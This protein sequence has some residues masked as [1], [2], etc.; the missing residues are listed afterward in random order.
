MLYSVALLARYG[1]SALSAVWDSGSISDGPQ[2]FKLRMQS[3]SPVCAFLVHLLGPWCICLQ[4][5]QHL[6]TVQCSF[7]VGIL[8]R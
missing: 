3:V 7:S 5:Q 2:P 4:E 6:L 1:A 8:C